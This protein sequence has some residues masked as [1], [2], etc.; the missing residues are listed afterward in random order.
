[1]KNKL[2]V[3]AALLFALMACDGKGPTAPSGVDYTS[4]P[5]PSSSQSNPTIGKPYPRSP[6][7]GDPS[8]TNPPTLVSGNANHSSVSDV[9]YTFELWNEVS[10]GDPHVFGSGLPEGG[11]ET[12]FQV[13]IS[14]P[15][16]TRYVWR[17]KVEGKALDGSNIS[18]AD[19][20]LQVFVTPK[21]VC[22]N[23]GRSVSQGIPKEEERK[24]L[25]KSIM[26]S[27][28]ALVRDC[29]G[30]PYVND[31]MVRIVGELQKLDPCWGYMKKSPPLAPYKTIPRDILAYAWGGESEGS[32]NFFVIDFVGSGCDNNPG[33]EEFSKPADRASF[34]WSFQNAP[35]CSNCTS[36]YAGNGR[37]SSTPDNF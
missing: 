29:T 35:Y 30:H 16:S 9:K 26:D 21:G 23:A 19:S 18:G 13:P 20:D 32:Q 1:M 24:Q 8:Q 10:P 14:L 3:S 36:G 17:V 6:I 2:F 7:G 27:N 31:M 5:V 34:A 4:E 22:N 15:H 28:P 12:S 11:G 25:I 37:W 33:S